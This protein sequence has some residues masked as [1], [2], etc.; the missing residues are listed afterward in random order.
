MM[1]TTM[2]RA[3][4]VAALFSATGAPAHEHYDDASTAP[5]CP[6]LKCASTVSAA[7]GNDGAL[8][9]VW[10]AGGRVSIAKSAD[11]G[12]S[13]S[14]AATLPAR[15]L[16]LDNGPDARPKIAVARDGRLVVTFATRDPKFNGHAF[17]IASNDGGLTFSPPA[18]IAADSPSQRFETAAIDADGRAFVTWIDKRNVAAARKNN[19][20][21][22]GATLAVAWEKSPGGALG[23]ATIARDNTCECC[24]IAVAFAGPGKPVVVFRNIF[25][26]GIRDHAV[27]TFD[28]ATPGPLDRVSDDDAKLDAC[29]HHGPSIAIGPDGTYHVTW[30]A[31]GRKLKG[32]FYARSQD[33]GKHFST[34]MPLGDGAR[35]MSRPYVLA[36]AD[37]VYLA[38]KTFDGERT[39]IEVKSSRDG[40]KT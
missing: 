10:A 14:P 37:G 21:Y 28:G 31:L 25:D 8:W 29:P 33:S 34:P 4:A 1:R 11:L 13:M 15:E 38:Y 39:T 27:I 16:P 12:K 36:G 22:A 30:F 17:V 23:E 5:S 32:L 24:R 19:V 2:L 7:F 40:G 26:G 3:L 6:E 9:L 20:P 35:Q 18:P